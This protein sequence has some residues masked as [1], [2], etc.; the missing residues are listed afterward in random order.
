MIEFSAHSWA[1]N[2][3]TLTE[4]LGTIARLG[5]RY[6]DIGSGAHFNPV[7]AIA[8][9]RRV[10]ADIIA[11]LRVYNLK[12]A[13]V[14]LL[15]PRIS[16]ADESSRRYEI[17]QF[18]A[19]IPIIRAIGAAGVTLSAG[20]AVPDDEDAYKRSVEA[21]MEM[22][23]AAGDD[24]SIGIEPHVDSVVS[25]PDTA[26]KLMED[27]PGLSLTLDWAQFVQQ[28]F[29]QDDITRLLPH[30]R[31]VHIRQAAQGKLQTAFDAGSI[32]FPAIMRALQSA[33]YR[34]VVC[35]EYLRS[36]QTPVNV[37]R[38]TVKLRDT[39]RSARKG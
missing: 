15:L 24:L 30:T 5:F 25:T 7:K 1:F 8:D 32:D 22:A 28:G 18:K 11:D 38:E 37:I 9:G 17:D 35:I 4:A 39:L 3:L 19:M 31:H 34:G 14:Y 16:L 21:L 6:A 2:D 13:D 36:T 12:L 10:A 23:E 26:L 20:V 33:D 27:V 29:A